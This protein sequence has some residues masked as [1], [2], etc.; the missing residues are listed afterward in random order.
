[1]KDLLCRARQPV[2]LETKVGDG[3]DTEL[4]DL[5]AA[6]GTQPEELVDG[7]CLRGDMRALLEQLPDLQGR[8]LKMRY[9]IGFEE[10]MSLSSIA[11][12]LEMSRDRARS[13]ERRAHEE[14]RRLSRELVGYLV[15]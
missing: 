7:E 9:G 11:R 2:S 15:A 10:P 5:L 6:E 1:V 12:E 13:L 3:D 4:L 14:L 8:V